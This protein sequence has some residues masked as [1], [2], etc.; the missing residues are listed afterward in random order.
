MCVY[1][2]IPVPIGHMNILEAWL[3]VCAW[4]AGLFFIAYG[5]TTISNGR[6]DGDP[7][8]TVS[9]FPRRRASE[10]QSPSSASASSFH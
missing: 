2:A 5:E 9:A 4:R 8:A 1:D 3:C 10:G 6:G 7:P